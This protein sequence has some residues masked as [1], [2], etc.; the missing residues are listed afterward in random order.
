M[1]GTVLWSAPEVLRGQSDY[2]KAADVYSFGIVM[3]ECWTREAP[4]QQPHA[5]TRF[6]VQEHILQGG[7][8][9]CPVSVGE[10]PAKY[11]E[12]MRWC[13]TEEPARRPALDVVAEM[14]EKIAVD[15]DLHDAAAGSEARERHEVSKPRRDEKAVKPHG[16]WRGF[17][18]HRDHSLTQELLPFTALEGRTM[19]SS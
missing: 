19:D 6:N 13:W 16:R 5:P 4:F 14:L 15:P 11:G 2:G 10:P 12:V 18:S 1:V 17:W 9:V 3:F 7:R 8:P